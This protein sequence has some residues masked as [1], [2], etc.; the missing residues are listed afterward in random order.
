MAAGLTVAAEKLAA[1]RE[2]LDARAAEA[3]G[4]GEPVAGS[5]STAR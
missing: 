5:R 4:N 3:L 1:L 2:T